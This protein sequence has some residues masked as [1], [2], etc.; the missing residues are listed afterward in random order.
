MSAEP[1]IEAPE[2]ADTVRVETYTVEQAARALNV[3]LSTT[4]QLVY[5]G[6]LRSVKIGR[7]VRIPVWAIDEYLRANIEPAEGPLS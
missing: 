3:G 7:L 6:H 4:K 2:T 1:T 5:A